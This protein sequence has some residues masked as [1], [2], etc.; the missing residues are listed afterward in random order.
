MCGK[1]KQL[2]SILQGRTM[3]KRGPDRISVKRGFWAVFMAG[4]GQKG[5]ILIDY[6]RNRGLRGGIP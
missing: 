4:M 3:Q 2:I 1:I 6:Q 5:G